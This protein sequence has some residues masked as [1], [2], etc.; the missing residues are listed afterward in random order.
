MHAV[1]EDG[2]YGSEGTI[3]LIV[4]P[5]SVPSAPSPS[6]SSAPPGEPWNTIMNRDDDITPLQLIIMNSIW[7]GAKHSYVAFDDMP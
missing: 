1:A 5:T 3:G 4:P 6:S 2:D 7:H